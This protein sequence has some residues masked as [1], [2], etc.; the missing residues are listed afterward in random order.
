MSPRPADPVRCRIIAG[1]GDLR[2]E[3]VG[4]YIVIRMA[5]RDAK[6]AILGPG[7]SGDDQGVTGVGGTVRGEAP[8]GLWVEIDHVV[9][10]SG[11]QA[12]LNGKPEHATLI[13]WDYITNARLYP[14]KPDDEAL[15]TGQYL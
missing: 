13:R 4:K 10:P 1:G 8:V 15:R 12:E 3:I 9:N 14:A 5:A 11:R 7:H 6:I 2:M